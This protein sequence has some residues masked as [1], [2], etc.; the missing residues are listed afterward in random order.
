MTI[1]G[2]LT[3]ISVSLLLVGLLLGWQ[4]SV[5]DEDISKLERAKLTLSTIE[6]NLLSMRRSEKDFLLRH[7]L[8]YR[9]RFLTTYFDVKKNIQQLHVYMKGYRGK[10]KYAEQL[11][12]F[13]VQLN[14]S[15][16]QYS[17]YFQMLVTIQLEIGADQESG[18]RG[19]VRSAAHTVEKSIQDLG[20]ANLLGA[21][22]MLRRYETD[23]LLHLDG[24]Y[25]SRFESSFK[26]VGEEIKHTHLRPDK[27][28][29]DEDTLHSIDL[30]LHVYHSLFL[31]LSEK[32]KQVGLNENEGVKGEMRS[33]AHQVEE[34]LER[35]S[36]QLYGYIALHIDS[37]KEIQAA[38]ALSVFLML[39]LSIALLARSIIRST[40]QLT[41][42][43]RMVK[44][45]GD[46]SKRVEIYSQ[47]EIGVLAASFNEMVEKIE[48]EHEEV[49]ELLEK[50]RIAEE[51]DHAKN[52]FL[53]TMSHELRTPLASIIGNSDLLLNKVK[54]TAHLE[55]IRSIHRSGNYQLALVDDI[56]DISKIESGTFTIEDGP[57][58]FVEF[59]QNIEQTFSVMVKE[60]GIIF[61]VEQKNP[62]PFQL[63]GDIQRINQVVINLID[64]AVKFTEEGSVSLT[65]EVVD[66]QLYFTVSDTGI[67][68]PADVIDQLFKQ[69]YQ[70]DNSISRRFG[71]SGLGLFIS[72]NLAKIMEGDIRVESEIDEGSIFT[73]VLPYQQSD[74]PAEQFEAG[75]ESSSVLSVRLTGNVL[76]AEDTPDLQIF[77]RKLLE[78]MGL[79]VTVA[80]NGEEAVS[81]ELENRF[82]LILMDMQMP[83][84]DG[85]EATKLLR[86]TG[87]EVPIFALTAN[88]M[89]KHRDAV[90]EAGSNGFIS[91]P[92]DIKELISSIRP[93][94]KE[95]QEGGTQPEIEVG[96][97]VDDEMKEAFIKVVRERKEGL[98]VAVENEDWPAV[99]GLAHAVKGTAATF[100]YTA[101]S[102][103]SKTIQN[104][105]DNAQMGEVP[106]LTEKLINELSEVLSDSE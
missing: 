68:M 59:I 101:L 1:K 12:P 69:F 43:I 103:L 75:Q 48:K 28:V 100:G 84:M 41:E 19:K 65:T 35:E 33:V 2:K 60:K 29:N 21:L 37:H 36:K 52:N 61:T 87:S 97:L 50:T 26:L 7:N 49:I 39:L 45:V 78:K 70:A 25:L 74:L 22:L 31:Q 4:K 85:I 56:L 53:A 15:L 6:K 93:F 76:I 32:I 8:K 81:Q 96:Q 99:R 54:D 89:Q 92:I 106:A 3:S 64:N 9:E 27:G 63:Y 38:T 98:K 18:L 67:G 13:F 30:A 86:A 90:D 94:L 73:L 17:S 51:V 82:D 72:M 47:D 5:I 91:K 23:F 79:T 102:E 42:E 55:M 95:S 14:R 77:E 80:S 44:T 62:E 16:D 20:D 71:G 46:L 83:V 104:Q 40:G 10:H 105:V 57:Y 58:T 24:Q 11:A 34:L 66:Q 88:V